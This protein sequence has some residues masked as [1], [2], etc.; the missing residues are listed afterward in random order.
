MRK[1]SKERLTCEELLVRVQLRRALRW[2][3][4]A[5]LL[6]CFKGFGRAAS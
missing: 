3:A 5:R 4:F 1:E 6:M 2:D